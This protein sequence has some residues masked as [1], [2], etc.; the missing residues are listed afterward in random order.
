M[1]SKCQIS[2]YCLFL[3]THFKAGLAS[4]LFGIGMKITG[5][6]QIFVDTGTCFWTSWKQTNIWNNTFCIGWCR[7]QTPFWLMTSCKKRFRTSNLRC[8]GDHQIYA[9]P[10][11]CPEQHLRGILGLW[12]IFHSY[13]FG[14]TKFSRCLFLLQLVQ[15][16]FR[17]LGHVHTA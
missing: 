16:T 9:M 14:S 6:R 13:C 1:C 11:P 7:G 5:V 15:C 3:L 17:S 8:T 4:D 10:F 12:D 2:T